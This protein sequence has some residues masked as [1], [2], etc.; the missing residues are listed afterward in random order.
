MAVLPPKTE[1][2]VFSIDGSF[3]ASMS[4][5]GK[6]PKV[7]AG[8]VDVVRYDGRQNHNFNSLFRICSYQNF[9]MTQALARIRIPDYLHH[10]S[11]RHAAEQSSGVA[12]TTQLPTRH[13]DL[14]GRSIY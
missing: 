8:A 13:G 4:I 5:M 11:S 9:S 12:C 14:H 7:K 1:C 3:T 6:D 10:S 2:I